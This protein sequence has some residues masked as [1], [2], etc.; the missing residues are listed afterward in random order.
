[1]DVVKYLRKNIW[2]MLYQALPRRCFF[3]NR[4]RCRFESIDQTRASTKPLH[5]VDINECPFIY[6]PRAHKDWAVKLKM[7]SMTENLFRPRFPYIVTT[8]GYSCFVFHL[9]NF[10]YQITPLDDLAKN[11]V[12]MNWQ[13]KS[14][15]PYEVDAAN[16]FVPYST[17][18]LWQ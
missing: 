12:W 7:V 13:R 9:K 10:F 3:K 5:F 8:W 2:R 1:M 11:Y 17:I 15:V 6:S 18:S 14:R 16:S 4:N